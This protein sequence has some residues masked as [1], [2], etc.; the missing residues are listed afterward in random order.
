MTNSLKVPLKLLSLL[1]LF[2]AL[3]YIGNSCTKF[4]L[5]NPVLHD[6]SFVKKFFTTKTTPNKEVAGVI[7]KLKQENERNDFVSKLPAKCGLPVWDKLIIL[8]KSVVSQRNS[9]LDQD[10]IGNNGNT[11][12]IPL[13]VSDE[14]LSALLFI[15]QNEDGTYRIN[16]ITQDMLNQQVHITD[17]DI[18]KNEQKLALFLYFENK[19]W[20]T[21]TFYHIPPNLFGGTGVH[22]GEEQEEKTLKL[23][24][25][26]QSSESNLVYCLQIHFICTI[27]WQMSCEYSWTVTVCGY[28]EDP[29]P[30]GGGTGGGGTGGGGGGTGGGGGCPFYLNLVNPCDPPPPPPTPPPCDTFIV[31]LT[32]DSVFKAKFNIL[33]SQAVTTLTYEKGFLVVDKN[34]NNYTEQNGSLTEAIIP[35]SISGPISGL[36]HSHFA[37]YNSIFSI[38]DLEFM[39]RLYL[40]GNARDS[41][42]FFFG[43]TSQDANPYLLKVTNTAKFRLLAQRIT[44][45]EKKYVK[46]KEKYADK[47]NT[48]DIEANERGFL[49]MLNEYGAGDGVSL[50]RSNSN[51]SQWSRLSVDNFGTVSSYSCLQEN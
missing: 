48:T 16:C 34:A 44:S 40:N 7:E 38:D 43:V 19:I 27:C 47:I 18:A 24:D 20:G 15:T 41:A 29:D 51:L 3:I 49:Q 14:Y 4:D 2:A 46:I 23:R 26:T 8:Q 35:Y 42:N 25:S 45:T 30:G 37:G 1:L 12:I 32:A 13:T 6:E 9:F 10:S 21:S 33:N 22:E 36:L 50:F 17:A 5:K 31:R 11:I 28:E 39:S